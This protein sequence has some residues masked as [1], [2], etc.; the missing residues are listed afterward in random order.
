MTNMDSWTMA[1]YDYRE[2]I[3]FDRQF[4]KLVSALSM[5]GNDRRKRRLAEII[6]QRTGAPDIGN[7]LS[8]AQDALDSRRLTWERPAWLTEND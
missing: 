2:K 5:R 6:Q 7:V 3:V 1:Y 4:P 8:A